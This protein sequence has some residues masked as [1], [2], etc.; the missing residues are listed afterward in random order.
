M[1]PGWRH[2]DGCHN[3]TAGVSGAKP[4]VTLKPWLLRV[5]SDL[6][7]VWA[8]AALRDILLKLPRPAM[9]VLLGCDE[10]QVGHLHVILLAGH[11]QAA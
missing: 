6:E 7:G 8:D 10:L 1:D 11:V 5:L 3:C 9:E 4:A 2:H